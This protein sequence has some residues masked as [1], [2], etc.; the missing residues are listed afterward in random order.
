MEWV[1]AVDDVD[2]VIGQVNRPDAPRQG[3]NVRAIQ[4][5]L[6]DAKGRLLIHELSSAKRYAGA[7]GASVAGGVKAG[8][9]PLQ[10][11]IRELREE[12]GIRSKKLVYRGKVRVTDDGI[13]K[14][15][16]VFSFVHDGGLTP[17]PEE[18][19]RIEWIDVDELRHLIAS[20][21]RR[22]TPTFEHAFTAIERA[23]I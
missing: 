14:F 19:A 3:A 6:F 16:T 7:W 23:L 22:F 5:Y 10:A 15:I 20:G 1:G 17:A 13:T 11:A 8:E 4:V 21:A 2:R 12:L 9:T 18:I